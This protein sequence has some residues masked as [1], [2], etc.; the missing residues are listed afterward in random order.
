MVTESSLPIPTHP[1]SRGQDQHCWLAKIAP[2]PEIPVRVEGQDVVAILDLGSMVTLVEERMVTSATLLPDKV[3]VSCIHGD[4]HYYPTV[5]LSILTPK[6]RCTVRAGKV[7]QLKV[8]SNQNQ[9]Y[10]YSPSYIS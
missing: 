6:G 5:N 3:V 7:P 8:K 1:G 10:L 9:I 2:A 4:T